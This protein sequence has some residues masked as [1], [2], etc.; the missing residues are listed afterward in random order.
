M[1]SLP[2]A[3]EQVLTLMAKDKSEGSSQDMWPTH[4]PTSFSLLSSAARTPPSG[5]LL[6]L[7]LF[8]P[9]PLSVSTF[10]MFRFSILPL[11]SHQLLSTPYFLQSLSASL[12]NCSESAVPYYIS[13]QI[14]FL[15]IYCRYTMKNLKTPTSTFREFF[16]SENFFII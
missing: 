11:I 16:P 3:G 12:S 5:G 4:C 8:L 6:L 1:E 7:A 13:Y 9:V 15:S 14:K 2:V 10:R